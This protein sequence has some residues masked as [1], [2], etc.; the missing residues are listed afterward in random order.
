MTVN[1]AR[2]LAGATTCFV[3]I[4]LPSTA[5][6]L[7][8]RTHNT[9][10][11]L[12]Y[13][14]GTIGS[15]PTRL[16]LSIGDG[17]LADT[18]DAVVSVPEIFNYWL[19][20]G[21]IDVGFLGAAQVDAH[22]N[23]NT[24]LVDRG[25]GRPSGRLPGAGGAPEIAANC[26]R[27]L[28]VLRHTTRNFVP[29]LDFVTTVGHGSGPG[30]RARLGLRGAGPTAVITDLGILTPDPATAE[31]TLTHLHPGVTVERVRAATGWDLEVART[32]TTTEPPTTAELDALRAL[33]A[34][35]KD[36]QR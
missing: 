32:L 3:G 16:P 25:P 24:T 20:A 30:D 17:E 27:V 11:I 35:G 5:A 33:R 15:K 1:A 2:A 10:L 8:R 6:N 23:I 22:G 28:M 31:L 21:R 36:D 7:A 4:G 26:G 9:D 34:A 12:I 13:E 18:A 14:S 29:R 19:Q